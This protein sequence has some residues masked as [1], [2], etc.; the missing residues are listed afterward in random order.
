MTTPLDTVAAPVD[1]IYLSPHLDD[2][3]FS[4][5]GQIHARARRG[6]RVSIVTLFAGPAPPGAELSAFASDLHRRWGLDSGDAVAVRRGEDRLAA[7]SLGAACVQLD[8]PDAIYRVDRRGV[9]LYTASAVLFGDP[10]E[11]DG[12][13]EAP[14]RAALEALPATAFVAAPLGIGG[15]VDHAIVHRLAREVVP[16]DRLWFYEDFPYA[17][18]WRVRRRAMARYRGWETRAETIDDADL[19]AK[20][21]AFAC[22]ASQL[23]SDW[24]DAVARERRLRRFHRRRGGER[25]W[26]SPPPASG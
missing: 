7:Q 8:L 20:S 21:R 18:S 24:S 15:H 1:A 4:C 11:D 25:L 2:A 3:A 19:D 23:G 22:Y 17:E 10:A 14:L 6:E 13:V 26:R 16:R 5:G 12:A 9:P